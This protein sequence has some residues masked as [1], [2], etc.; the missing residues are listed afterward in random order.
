MTLSEVLDLVKRAGF[1]DN[2]A[3][4]AAAVA[5]A[6]SGGNPA[7]RNVNVDGSVD[8]GLFQIN[9]RWH[10]EVSDACAFNPECA[11]RAAYRISNQGTNWNQWSAY[12]NGSYRQF[13][14]ANGTQDGTQISG[15]VANPPA[16]TPVAGMIA[17]GIV[18]V[19]LLGAGILLAVRP[20]LQK[21]VSV[22]ASATPV[23]RAASVIE[24]VRRE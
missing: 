20:L 8:R 19:G 1:S 17:G 10:P 23:G 11:A 12:K 18:G 21:G 13:L 24:Q 2:T 6:E 9:A 14:H 15:S 16:S 4:L 7:A 5:M 3:P 22:A